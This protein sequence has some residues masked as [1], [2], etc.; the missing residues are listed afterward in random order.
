MYFHFYFKYIFLPVLKYFVCKTMYAET[1]WNNFAEVLKQLL[2]FQT[3]LNF[4]LKM[5]ERR[6]MYSKFGII[7]KLLLCKANISVWG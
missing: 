2:F 4:Y 6:Q 3:S 1:S 5:Q 7:N